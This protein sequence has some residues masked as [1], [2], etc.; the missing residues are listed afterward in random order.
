MSCSFALC[1]LLGFVAFAS[2][3]TPT[4]ST[5]EIG[6]ISYFLPGKP[7]TTLASSFYS[8]AH[9]GANNVGDRLVPVTVI[10]AESGSL[11]IAQIEQTIQG[12]GVE[13]DVWTTDFLTSRP[14][15]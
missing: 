15:S 10:G 8:Q 7:L 1:S 4:G 6:G 9:P 2:A 12:F 13:D 5:V 3:L 11:S 14:L